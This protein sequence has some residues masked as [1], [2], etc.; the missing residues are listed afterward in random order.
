MVAQEQPDNLFLRQG[1]LWGVSPKSAKKTI[2]IQIEPQEDQTHIQCYSRL[3]SDWK[4]ITWIGC[5]LAGILSAVCVWIASD[6][7]GVLATKHSSFWSWLITVDGYV[8]SEVGG[9]FVR[10]LWGLSGFLSVVIALEAAILI[11]SSAK[12]DAFAAEVL[13]GFR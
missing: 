7:T 2:T 8:N 1:S 11:Y 13:E 10:L 3:S 12:I 5:V 9:V 4:N 6:L